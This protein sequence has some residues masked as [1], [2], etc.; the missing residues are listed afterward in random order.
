MLEEGTFRGQTLSLREDHPITLIV[1]A[2]G[3]SGASACNRYWA[4][5]ERSD[6]TVHLSNI[7]AQAM[8]CGDGVMALDE[9]FLSMVP[10]ISSIDDSDPDVLVVQGPDLILRFKPSPHDLP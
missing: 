1:E 2:S 6:G 10:K 4:D 7:Y 3:L 9:A 5:M 8:D